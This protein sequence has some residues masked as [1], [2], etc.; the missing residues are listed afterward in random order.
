[1]S[2]SSLGRGLSA[3]LGDDINPSD[4]S[5]SNN[6]LIYLESDRLHPGRMQ[7]R[8][9]FKQETLDALASSIL[10]KGI[11]QPLLVRWLDEAHES[12][13]IIAGERRWRAAHIAGIQRIPVI[14]VDYSD[15]ECLEVGLIENLQRDD[16]NPIEE[17]ESLKRL[18]HEYNRTQEEVAQAV[19]KS[20]SYV[21][22]ALRL[23]TLP[24]SVQN[25]IRRDELSPGHARTLVNSVD[26]EQLAQRIVDEK[27]TV[28][29]AES[30][31][32]SQH[33]ENE[34]NPD[35]V[36]LEKEFERITGMS[37][38]LKTRRSGGGEVRLSFD[39]MSQL[40]WLVR[41]LSS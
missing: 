23:L 16:L 34:K 19:G 17:A 36:F 41:K 25:R 27:M 39:N 2:S 28:R 8:K 31:Q 18:V 20:R 15:Q 12:A 38:Q 26:A 14:V 7:P 29:D 24:E 13:E 35:I 5:D 4:L 30:W 9:D 22:N 10:Q 3:L 33:A 1:M 21:A 37:T 40:D 6:S 32:K 11:L